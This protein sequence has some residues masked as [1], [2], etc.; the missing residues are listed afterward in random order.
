MN[1][2]GLMSGNQGVFGS[3]SGIASGGDIFQPIKDFADFEG[4]ISDDNFWRD[5]DK[6]PDVKKEAMAYLDR[7]DEKEKAS[8][9]TDYSELGMSAYKDMSGFAKAQPLQGLMGMAQYKNQP[10]GLFNF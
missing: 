5:Y 3:M 2:F 8:P 6:N 7:D 1:H 9:I 4:R 10:K